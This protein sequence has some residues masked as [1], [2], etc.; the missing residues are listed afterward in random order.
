MFDINIDIDDVNI[1]SIEKEDIVS[2]QQ[3][4]NFQNYNFKDK[5]K[6][7]GLREFYERFLEYYVSEGEFFLKINKGA[8]L[9]GVLKGRIEF[10]SSNEVWFWYFLLDNECRGKGIGSSII[11]AVQNHFYQGFGINDFYTGVCEQDTKVL[12]F[13]RKNNYKLIRVSKGFFNVNEEDKDMLILKK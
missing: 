1:S 7:L 2:L 10:K 11:K 5:E 8:M 13:W 12:R 3:W 9:I 4:I 6:P